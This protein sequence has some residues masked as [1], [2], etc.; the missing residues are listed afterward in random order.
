[1]KPKD[2]LGILYFAAVSAFLVFETNLFISLTKEYPYA[3]GFAKFAVL[4]TFGECLKNRIATPN[5]LPSKLALRFLIWGVFGLWISA[6]FPFVDGGVKAITMSGLWL[7]TQP[8]FWMSAWINLLG[9]YGFFM[10]FTH[11]WADTILTRGFQWPWQVLGRPETTRW[12]KIVIVSLFLF[13][14]PAHTFTF[15]LPPAW[16]VICAAYLSICLGLIL[17]F[18]ARRK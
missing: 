9:G 5:W 1:M 3:M 14:I 17:S 15:S 12:A 6:V 4:A 8:A 7:K 16:R 13:W 18:A 10:M 11:Y 2:V